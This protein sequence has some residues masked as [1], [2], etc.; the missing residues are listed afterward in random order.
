MSF[1]YEDFVDTLDKFAEKCNNATFSEAWRYTKKI[2]N[3]H[4]KA[5]KP[6]G[7]SLEASLMLAWKQFEHTVDQDHEKGVIA[8]SGVVEN[9]VSSV[10]VGVGLS[11]LIHLEIG[12]NRARGYTWEE[13]E[14]Y[15]HNHYRQILKDKAEEVKQETGL[16]SLK[17]V[18]DDP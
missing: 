14:E 18:R 7:I 16:P 3:A 8:L 2:I 4:A 17:L 13:S 15:V 9:L 11:F 12:L 10:P 1:Y 6:V 5:T